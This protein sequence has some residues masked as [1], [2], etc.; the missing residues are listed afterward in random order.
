MKEKKLSIE[1]IK[2]QR[3]NILNKLMSKEEMAN[4]LQADIGNQRESIKGDS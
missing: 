3:Q 1:P 4:E 2:Y